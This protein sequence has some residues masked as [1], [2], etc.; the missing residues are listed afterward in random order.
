MFGTRLV[1]TVVGVGEEIDYREVGIVVE[2]MEIVEKY[3]GIDL[4]EIVG[5][6][7]E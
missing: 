7:E 1:E 6:V 5:G 4:I 2:E 3:I